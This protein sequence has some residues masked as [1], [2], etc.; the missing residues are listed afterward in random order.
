MIGKPGV[1]VSTS[2]LAPG[3]L[4]VVRPTDSCPAHFCILCLQSIEEAVNRGAGTANTRRAGVTGVATSWAA[5]RLRVV[6]LHGH[7]SGSIERLLIAI[8]PTP[9][10]GKEQPAVACATL[11][12]YSRVRLLR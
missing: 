7:A 3:P 12:Q 8:Q 9:A 2:L 1:L 6:L 10:H 11:L 5:G 4:T